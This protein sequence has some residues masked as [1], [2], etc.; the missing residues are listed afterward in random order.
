MR[1]FHFGRR[2]QIALA[3]ALGALL[4]LA[5]GAFALDR[6]NVDEVADGV[7]VGGVEVGGLST[8]E[9]RKRLDARLAG[10]LERPVTVIFEKTKYRLSPERL[11]LRADVEGMVDAALDASRSGGLPS[12]VWRYATGGS[13]DREITPQIAYSAEALDGF[14]EEVVGEIDRPPRDATVS[15]SP[16][17]LN[18]VP[19]EDGV[20]VR[21]EA[22]LSRLRSAID[23]PDRR[24]VTVPA[25]RVKPEVTTDELAEQYPAYI[26]IDRGAFELRLWKNPELAKTYTIA[27]GAAGYETSTG[28]YNIESKQ[29]N[30]TWYVPDSDW[31][32]D[33][34]GEVVPPGPDNPLQARWMGFFAGAGI[35]GT[36]DVG[37]LGSAASHGCI[38]M[39][40]PEVIELY[41]Q[42][43]LGTPIYIGN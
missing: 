32:G 12:R 22:L 34:A 2:V 24:V 7:R 16:A 19:A 18:A 29:V 14:L 28:V 26:T 15:P 27:V 10:E 3:A 8:D 36:N 43:P 38:R 40:V 35:H 13:V 33:L 5:V 1:P 37:S 4:V 9:A 11:E 41:D 21:D 39:S 6:A 20:T 23:S 25:D 31:A 17:S 42:V 30:P